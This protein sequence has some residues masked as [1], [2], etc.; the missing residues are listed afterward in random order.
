[1]DE[2]RTRT[3]SPTAPEL[4]PAL[5]QAEALIESWVT[6]AE[7]AGRLGVDVAKV[8]Q[9]LRE[10]QLLAVRRDGVQRIP[11]VFVGD[12]R[13]LKGLTGTLNVLFDNR[14]TEGAALRWLFTFD[15]SLPGSPVQALAEN[16]GTEVKRRAQAL[17]F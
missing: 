15:D 3:A 10:R 5:E 9:F 6:V 13:L 11:A 4:D 12:G 7:A 1:M 17:A 2:S 8:R 14:F 16:R